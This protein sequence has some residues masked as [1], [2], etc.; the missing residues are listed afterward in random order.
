MKIQIFP[1]HNTF[2]LQ[3]WNLATSTGLCG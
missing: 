3:H 1:P 2:A